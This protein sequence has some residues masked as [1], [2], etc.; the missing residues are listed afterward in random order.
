MKQE[1]GTTESLGSAGFFRLL[2]RTHECSIAVVRIGLLIVVSI[3]MLGFK[4]CNRI[5]PNTLAPTSSETKSMA[6]SS[7]STTTTKID[8]DKQV[9]PILQSRC[10]PCHFPGGK[11]YDRMPFDR[12][13]TIKTLGTRLFTR[14]KDE[15][16]RSVIREFLAQP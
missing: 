9:K 12:P 3:V 1:A 7:S 2:A 5:H 11:V 15:G 10:M 13:E 14:I 6:S 16:E 4:T 8:F